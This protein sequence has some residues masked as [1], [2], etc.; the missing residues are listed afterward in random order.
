MHVSF[1]CARQQVHPGLEEPAHT[2]N[3]QGHRC[4]RGVYVVHRTKGGVSVPIILSLPQEAS[5]ISCFVCLF[6]FVYFK[7]ATFEGSSTRF[8]T[9]LGLQYVCPWQI[10]IVPAKL[11]GIA[12]LDK[13]QQESCAS[14]CPESRSVEFTY[15]RA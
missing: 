2:G 5:A 6:L 14:R 12:F 7:A 15:Y 9:R 13:T 10:D 1:A 8:A 11:S 4:P 3:P